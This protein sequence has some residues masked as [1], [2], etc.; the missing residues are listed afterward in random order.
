MSWDK[1]NFREKAEAISVAVDNGIK[2]IDGI[3]NAYNKFG[4]G[5]YKSSKAVRKKISSWEGASMYSPTPDTGRVNSSFEDE[6]RR[7]NSVFP[8]SLQKGLTQEQLD[9]LFS[10][11]Y[12]VGAGNF[13][14]RVIPVLKQ[15]QEGKATAQDV[16]NA[17]YATKD[18]QYRGLRTRRVEERRMFGGGYNFINPDNPNIVAGIDI[19]IPQDYGKQTVDTSDVVNVPMAVIPKDNTLATVTT[20]KPVE[21]Y[22]PFDYQPQDYSNQFAFYNAMMLPTEYTKSRTPELILP[23]YTLTYNI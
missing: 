20:E 10:Y 14:K 2:D 7:F 19:S 13:K 23:D 16:Q 8:L 12:N 17:M 11:S 6:E 1:L 21:N 9:G 4:D 15:M 3:R 18:K 5:G 22:N